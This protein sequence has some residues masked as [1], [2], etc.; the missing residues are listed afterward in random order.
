[1]S[2]YDEK[3]VSE[4]AY[5]KYD[6]ARFAMLMDGYVAM[7]GEEY[8][9]ENRRLQEDDSVVFP[10]ELEE[11]CMRLINRTIAQKKRREGFDKALRAAKKLTVAAAVFL[12]VA[13]VSTAVL[14]NTVEAFRMIVVDYAIDV[15]DIGEGSF[16]SVQANEKDNRE[17]VPTW[18]PEGY[19]MINDV[20]DADARAI[21]YSDGEHI[22]RY[23]RNMAE[24]FAVD[25]ENAIDVINAKVNGYDAMITIKTDKTICCWFDYDSGYAYLLVSDN[26]NADDLLLIAK[27]CYN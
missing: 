12:L 14:C 13:V 21:I 17:V 19:E 18:L 3:Y 10:E 1:V 24:N 6:D 7:L 25:T 23:S 8:A 11:K 16:V 15:L 27:S 5:E 20:R 9:E 22:L 2:S 26:I 4:D